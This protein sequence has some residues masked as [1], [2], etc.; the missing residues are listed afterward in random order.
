MLLE[1][2]DLAA[3]APHAFKDAVTVEKAVVIDADLGVFFVVILALC[4]VCRRFAVICYIRPW[5]QTTLRCRLFSVHLPPGE[6]TSG[7]RIR[8]SAP[9]R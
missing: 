8:L 4:N 1:T 7:C 9:G 3:V 5:F 6:R 2:E